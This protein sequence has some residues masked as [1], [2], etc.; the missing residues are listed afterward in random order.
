MIKKIAV[1]TLLV[2]LLPL[3]PAVYGWEGRVVKVIDGDSLRVIR[4][5]K[6]VELRLYGIDCPEWG[7]DYGNRAKR[8]AKSLL[9]KKEVIVEPVD[10]DRYN[11]VVALVTVSDKLVNREMVWA[12]LAWM[13]PKYCKKE[14]LCAEL[15]KIENRAR[16]G[17]KGLWQA[18]KPVS[19]WQWKWQNR[20]R[21]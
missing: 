20:K 4:G 5:K 1:L 18:K 11:R 21:K 7:Q 2:Y 14:P 19:P 10:V 13:Y 6:T 8:Y 3:V 9:N 17:R 12:G 15:K 16:K